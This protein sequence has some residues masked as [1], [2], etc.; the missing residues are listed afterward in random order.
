MSRAIIPPDEHIAFLAGVVDVIFAFAISLERAGVLPRAQIAA[1]LD[2][3]EKQQVQ[4]EGRSTT[5]GAVVHLLRQA[6]ELPVAGAQV[7]AGF[8]VVPGGRPD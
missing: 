6:F 2:E 7:R 5:R 1:V 3:V 8:R 4:Q